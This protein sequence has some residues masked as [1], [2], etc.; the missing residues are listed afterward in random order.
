MCTGDSKDDE[1]REWVDESNLNLPGSDGR[2]AAQAPHI[3]NNALDEERQ[4]IVRALEENQWNRREAAKAL[5]MPYSTLRY[6]IRRYE[7][8]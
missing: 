2:V 5:G 3:G 1:G 4:R 7:I 6:K 8:A